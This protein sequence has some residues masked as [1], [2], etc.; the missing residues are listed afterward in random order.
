MPRHPNPYPASEPARFGA[1]F[2]SQRAGMG[3][4]AR[5]KIGA[6]LRFT[7]L[8]RDDFTCRYC[9][10]SAPDARLEVD[11]VLAVASGGEDALENLATACTACNAG[12]SA[13]ALDAPIG[14][15]DP[16][17]VWATRLEY[18]DCPTHGRQ[19]EAMDSDGER[20]LLG[21]MTQGCP[22]RARWDRDG[23]TSLVDGD[24]DVIEY[25]RRVAGL[26]DE[27]AVGG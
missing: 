6:A 2:F 23:S 19:L 5:K 18:G 17:E 7:V 27:G 20:V 1:G 14:H 15:K 16:R 26:R 25:L 21:C 22:F 9:G 10:A 8:R 12:K 4:R 3:R 13:T 11:H 24:P